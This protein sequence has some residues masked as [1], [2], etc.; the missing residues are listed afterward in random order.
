MIAFL[1][2][3]KKDE[4]KINT[5]TISQF[6]TKQPAFSYFLKFVSRYLITTFSAVI[7]NELLRYQT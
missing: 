5:T 6:H 1:L 2:F 3:S 4:S 7:K